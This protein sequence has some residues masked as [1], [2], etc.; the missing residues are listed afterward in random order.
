MILE[1][2]VVSGD[3][4]SEFCYQ[5]KNGSSTDDACHHLAYV[6]SFGRGGRGEETLPFHNRVKIFQKL[7]IFTLLVHIILKGS[8]IRSHLM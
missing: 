3:L 6:A 1:K 5:E 7:Q 2:V 8:S 4:W